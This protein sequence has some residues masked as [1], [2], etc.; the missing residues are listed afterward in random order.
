MGTI[1]AVYYRLTCPNCEALE[2]VSARE[3]GSG[4]GASWGSIG[5]P[6]SFEIS[7]SDDGTGPILNTA[8][9]KVCRIDATTESASYNKPKGW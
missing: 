3:S 1:D 9:C 2:T 4:W 6:K 5:T 8:K 7:Q